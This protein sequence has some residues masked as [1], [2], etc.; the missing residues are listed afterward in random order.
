MKVVY[1]IANQ[2]LICLTWNEIFIKLTEQIL[3][4][5][6]TAAQLAKKLPFFV[7]DFPFCCVNYKVVFNYREHN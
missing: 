3:Y 5:K 1:R 7:L 4:E 6:I 2:S